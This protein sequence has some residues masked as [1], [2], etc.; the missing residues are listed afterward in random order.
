MAISFHAKNT[1]EDKE[2]ALK[3]MEDARQMIDYTPEDEDGMNDYFRIASGYA[4]IEPKTA[5]TMLENF[6]YQVNDLVTASALLAKYDKRNQS[7]KNGELLLTRG[8]PRL[9]RGIFG[10][11]KELS[12]LAKA[13]IDRL[14][15]ITDKFQRDDA[16]IL[17]RL[18]IAQA[19]FNEKIGLDGLN[20]N[21]FSFDG[22]EMVLTFGE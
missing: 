8:L 16:R 12:L 7:F 21:P 20:S 4:Y 1:K 2:T 5:F 6:S 10:Y 15:G 11:G 18:Y 14:R 13:D 17:L 3:L 19:F 9:G 22:G